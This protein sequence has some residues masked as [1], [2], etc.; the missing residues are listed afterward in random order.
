MSLTSGFA[1]KKQEILYTQLIFK[2]LQ[3]F[4]NALLQQIDSFSERQGITESWQ[5]R[6]CK[7]NRAMIYFEKQKQIA[8]YMSMA[9]RNLAEVYLRRLK[10]SKLSSNLALSRE[11]SID[12]RDELFETD[13][14]MRSVDSTFQ[15]ADLVE[16]K[17][18]S[19]PE[20]SQIKI[21]SNLEEQESKVKQKT[22]KNDTTQ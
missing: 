16:C 13:S 22:V 17:T 5:K 20:M 18:P 12:E 2:A 7:I 6:I 14:A 1:S 4:E 8:P 10:D 9:F 11:S 19:K 21:I 3:T 15:N